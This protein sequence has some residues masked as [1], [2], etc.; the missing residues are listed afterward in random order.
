MNNNFHDF[1]HSYSDQTGQS[2]ISQYTAKTFAWMFL[3]LMITFMIGYGLYVS[4]LVYV[5]L[6]V[7]FLHIGILIAEVAMVISLSA[8]LHKISLASARGLFIGY[9]VLN[10]VTFASIFVL[11]QMSSIIYV[12]LLT[13]LYFGAL[14]AYG[15]FTKTDLSQMG[16]FL[17][18]SLIILVVCSLISFIFPIEMLDR[19]ICIAGIALFMGYTAYDTQKIRHNYNMYSHDNDMLLKA[20]V[21]SALQL[22]LDFINLFLYLLRFMGNRKN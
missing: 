7:P 16:R 3:G 6:S 22:Y 14:S 21:I 17:S 8:R 18:I 12:F 10:G 1:D 9:A 19:V 11:Y 5:I 4:N 13:S 2:A 20:S 15:Y